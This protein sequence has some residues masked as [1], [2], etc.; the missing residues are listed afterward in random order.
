MASINGHSEAAKLLTE[1]N[2]KLDVKNFVNLLNN[3]IFN[4]FINL[5]FGSTPLILACK[6]KHLKVAEVLVE[7]G[8]SLDSVDQ[9]GHWRSI[10]SL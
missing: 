8:A 10:L 9:V 2:A 4:E 3:L 7:A 1:N 5:Q 6:N